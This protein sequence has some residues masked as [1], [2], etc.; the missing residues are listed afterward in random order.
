VNFIQNNLKVEYFLSNAI[1][2]HTYPYSITAILIFS[3][4]IFDAI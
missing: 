1:A 2:C 3:K 4:F